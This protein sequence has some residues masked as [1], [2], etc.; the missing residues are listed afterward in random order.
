M[1]SRL[2]LA[3]LF[4]ADPFKELFET[5]ERWGMILW[6]VII[7]MAV[8]NIILV[9]WIFAD[10]EKRGGGGCGSCFW[11]I[12]VL[13]FG[14]VGL[15]CYLIVRPAKREPT[16]III[17]AG[18]QQ[19][20][21]QP[22][23]QPAQV[24]Q[25]QPAQMMQ[26]P[27]PQVMQ[28]PPQQ[29]LP[30]AGFAPARPTGPFPVA[31]APSGHHPVAVQPMAVVAPVAPSFCSNCRGRLD[32]GDRFCDTCGSPVAVAGATPISPAS[33]TYTIGRE[34][35]SNIYFS[36]SQVS[37]RHGLL[38]VT[39]GGILIEDIGSSNG[40]FVNGQRIFS[41]TP[42]TPSDSIGFGSYSVSYAVLLSMV[43]R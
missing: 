19:V 26:Q 36:Q 39:P 14:L 33:G 34:P 37:G 16:Q 30:P 4:A 24:F 9:I 38:H 17:H 10:Y 35:D 41:R 21:Q 11:A 1:I 18:G 3:L 31:P 23:Q 22:V 12:F 29:A 2:S 15:L 20:S 42:I 25:P 43:R 7:V 6:T 27:Q 32:P 8:L 5:I 28:Q 40:T 13:H